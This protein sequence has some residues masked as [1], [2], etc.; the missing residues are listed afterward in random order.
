M[1][2]R[3]NFVG[4]GA[5]KKWK[6]PFFFQLPTRLYI[7]IGY[8]QRV[9]FSRVLH[10]NL[11]CLWKTH[12]CIWY[13]LT[14]NTTFCCLSLAKSRVR[15]TN[16]SYGAGTSPCA[17]SILQRALIGWFE[18]RVQNTYL[19]ITNADVTFDLYFIVFW[20]WIRKT[21]PTCWLYI[22]YGMYLLVIS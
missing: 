2:W 10:K 18:L 12:A 1:F 19:I 15:I 14:R 4:L 21:L 22:S 3:L 8:S 20:Y 17:N 11:T 13:I 9:L 6:D 7:L 16:T 5:K